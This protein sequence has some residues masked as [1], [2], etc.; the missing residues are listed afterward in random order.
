M[1]DSGANADWAAQ[2][3]E[4]V[5]RVVDRVRSTTSD[6]LVHLVRAVVYGLL[7]AVMGTAALILTA[8]AA[9]RIM[10]SYLPFAGRPAR[11]VWVADAIVGGIFSLTG[12]FLWSRRRP[13]QTG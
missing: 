4:T 11:A 9:V 10:D 7:A 8:I 5:T 3:A 2:T 13:P 1:P 12:L 6:R